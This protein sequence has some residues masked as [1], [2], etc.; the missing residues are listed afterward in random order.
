MYEKAEVE[1]E[2]QMQ[3][4]D[5]QEESSKGKVHGSLGLKYLHA[6][7]NLITVFSILLL[8]ILAQVAVSGVD[9]FVSYWSKIEEFRNVT[10]T[11]N[12]TVITAIQSE[13]KWSTDLCIYIYSALIVALFAIALT[14]SMTFYKLAMWS[15]ANLHNRMFD[16]VISSSMRFFDTNPS[17]RILNRFSK[18]IGNIDEWLPKAVLDAGQNSLVMIGSLVLI[19]LVNPYFLVLIAVI[20]TF[21]LLLGIIFLKSSKNI[22]RLEGVSKFLCLKLYSLPF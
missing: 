16:S 7:G 14:R 15:S 4:K 11:S 19:A 6:G 2:G 5:L 1:R 20:S 22:K 12:N 18:D 13:S 10:S 3:T 21:F 8:F 9:Y 17:G